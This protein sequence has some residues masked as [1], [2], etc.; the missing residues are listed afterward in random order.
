MK[1]DRIIQKIKNLLA[2]SKSPNE[3]EAANAAA[4]A[5][6]IMELHKIEMAMVHNYTE[7]DIGSADI[8]K[9][10]R[11]AQWKKQLALN[12]AEINDCFAF[13]TRR[14]IRYTT[15]TV[16][17]FAGPKDELANI[18][19]LY[20]YLRDQI[21]AIAKIKTSKKP[22]GVQANYRL[23]MVDTMKKRLKKAKQDAHEEA[24]KTL[25]GDVETALARS[26]RT[27]AIEAWVKNDHD[28]RLHKSSEY[29]SGDST[30]YR[31]GQ[32][33]GYKVSFEKFPAVTG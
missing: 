1:N 20:A 7:T 31:A 18:Q 9:S 13:T 5:Q 23:G 27:P 26:S 33:A 28:G 19:E 17:H 14:E 6:R 25:S 29:V 24:M 21:D 4:H 11:M 12:I 32:R 10:A 2:L 3:H 16:I 22:V 8:D 30:G 15:L